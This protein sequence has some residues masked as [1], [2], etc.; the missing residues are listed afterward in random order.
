MTDHIMIT[1]LF[2]TNMIGMIVSFFAG[3]IRG[4]RYLEEKMK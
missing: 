2:W 3:F 1:I 4:Y